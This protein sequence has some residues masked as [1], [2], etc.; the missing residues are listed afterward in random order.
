[1]ELAAGEVGVG[2][3]G[4]GDVAARPGA[5][6]G[7]GCVVLKDL[8]IRRNFAIYWFLFPVPFSFAKWL[9]FLPWSLESLRLVVSR[10]RLSS[11]SPQLVIREVV[12]PP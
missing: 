10:C 11:E 6:G 9:L 7:D 2:A 3:A 12:A 8:V 4:V 1:M 5:M